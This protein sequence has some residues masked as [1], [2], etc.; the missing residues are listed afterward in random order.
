MAPMI[1]NASPRARPTDAKLRLGFIQR[2]RVGNL[3]ELP[4]NSGAKSGDVVIRQL[5]P[6]GRLLYALGK[7]VFREESSDCH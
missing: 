6:S 5:F 2:R 1:A 4:G 3:G 7:K